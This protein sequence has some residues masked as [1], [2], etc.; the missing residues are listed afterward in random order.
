MKIEELRSRSQEELKKMLKE[1]AE[2]LHKLRFDLAFSRLKDLSTIQKTKRE[3]A[4]IKTLL[5]QK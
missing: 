4:K 3:I 1:N 2:K 5:N